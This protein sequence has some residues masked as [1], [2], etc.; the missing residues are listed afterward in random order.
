MVGKI[1][2]AEDEPLILELAQAEFEDAGYQVVVAADGAA[3]LA[4]L[5]RN[6]DIAVLFTDIRMP[7][8]IDGWALAR[9]ARVL[10]P[11][12]CVIYATGFSHEQ[13][14][15]V[16]GAMLFMKPYRFAHIV[17]AA[18]ALTKSS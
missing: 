15:L 1:L 6:P 18:R 2:I 12:L 11:D 17:D 8:E 7:G 16:D 9:S 10:R 14:Q 4:A 13:P 3:A 5:E